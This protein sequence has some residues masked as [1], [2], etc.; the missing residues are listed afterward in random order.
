MKRI[1]SL[2]LALFLC[3]TLAACGT[4]KLSEN[5]M[6][7]ATMD[8]QSMYNQ[9]TKKSVSLGMTKEEVEAI[10]GKGTEQKLRPLSIEP[11]YEGEANVLNSDI[12]YVSY[13]TGEDVLVISYGEDQAR[14]LS[15]FGN[16]EGV[17]PGPSHWCVKYGISYGAS[18]QEIMD[19]YGN[20]EPY[21][22]AP[23][24]GQ[25]QSGQGYLDTPTVMWKKPVTINYF[26]DQE[27]NPLQSEE[28]KN[29]TY[30]VLF[31]VDE[32]QDGLMWYAVES[33]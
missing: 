9:E 17:N 11:L 25:A 3:G 19:Q 21:P 15:S 30:Q 8:V 16:F 27:G 22:L 12:T 29:A 20:M 26:F 4:E 1:L 32:A 28:G 6:D 7:V 10:L 5:P 33:F 31:I 2:L 13:G 23:N 18:L 14:A 24:P